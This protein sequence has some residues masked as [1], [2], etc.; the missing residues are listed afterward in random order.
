MTMLSNRQ[1]GRMWL[2]SS[3]ASLLTDILYVTNV[4]RQWPLVFK[5]WCMYSSHHPTWII[6]KHQTNQNWGTFYKIPGW[7]FF[8]V[9][10]SWKTAWKKLSHAN[11]MGSWNWN[12]KR[13]LTWKTVKSTLL[14]IYIKEITNKGLLCITRNSTQYSVLTYCRIW[15]NESEKESIYTYI[16][17]YV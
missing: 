16:H 6:R 3:K 4:D 10:R 15:K 14:L 9:E 5:W 11:L 1:D 7:H 12:W 17:I 8:N 2:I 13:T